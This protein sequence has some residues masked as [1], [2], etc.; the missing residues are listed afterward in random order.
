MRRIQLPSLREARA[1]IAPFL[2]LLSYV[3]PYRWRF[4]TGTLCGAGFGAVSGAIPLVISFVGQA[5]FSDGGTADL[6]R[7]VESL[8][9]LGVPLKAF[10]V[11]VLHL[12]S[13]PKNLV[14]G[15]ACLLVPGV[16]L[17]RSIL[18]F[19]NAYLSE[20]TSQRVLIDVRGRLME[21]IMAQPLAFFNEARA[22][23]I[24]QRVA[25]ET[26]EVQSVLS[27]LNTQL[28][29]QPATMISGLFVLFQI[30]W[31]FTLGA[32]LL[33]PFCIG[34]VMVLSKK[35][36][37]LARGED[38]EGRDMMVILHEMLAGIKVIKAFSRSRYEL[39]RFAA[40]AAVQFRHTMRMRTLIESTAPI[41]ESLAAAGI[42]IGLFYVYSV[43]MSGSTFLSL[44]VGIFLLYQP[45]KTLSRLHLTLLR[46]HNV[47][48]G[49]FQLMARKPEVSDCPDARPLASCRGEIVFEDVLFSYRPGIAALDH[50]SFRFEPGKSY[51]LV[52]SSGA[53]KSTLLSLIMRFYDPQSGR[54]L[55]D[56][57][58]IR[59]L[60]Q[61]NLRD[62]IG[63]VTQETFLFH[64]SIRNNIAY[65]KP[66]ATDS[67]I[68][69]AARLAHAHEFILAQHSGYA[70][71]VG[72]KGCMLSGGQQQRISIARALLKNAPILLLDEATSS[73]DSESERHIQ[74][75]LETLSAGKTVIA[76]AHRLSTVLKSDRILVLEDGRLR[77]AGPHADLLARSP[78]Y[79]R[80]YELQF[81][82]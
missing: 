24:F 5:V 47:I 50:F 38:A 17:L 31:K 29:S 27:M 82:G 54:I 45:F 62:H 43:G 15:V 34:P 19:G 63:I 1:F 44:C 59:E 60:P 56:G 71:V 30:D 69:R 51:A 36:R 55:L 81:Q 7:G 40:S 25:N 64:D 2:E 37:G 22:G 48:V 39:D 18:D 14:V 67:E 20:W 80:L 57:R 8:G 33:L 12:D 11:G 26:R 52:G 3:K 53:G 10:A 68:E 6:T 23:N 4:L 78:I 46:S 16:M 74:D 28:I 9:P 49:V 58:D 70:T 41:V 76:I 66:G 61:D 32:L 42:A 13:V 65:G 35:L 73:L 75:A 72:D 79:R 21:S 77:D